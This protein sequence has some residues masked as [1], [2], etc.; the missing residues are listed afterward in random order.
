MKLFKRAVKSLA[1]LVADF[2]GSWWSVIIFTSIIS[3][4][5]IFNTISFTETWHVDKY[6]FSFLNLILGVFAALTGPLVLIG[7]KTQERRYQRLI[8]AIYT[9]EKKQHEVFVKLL[10]EYTGEKE[11]KEEK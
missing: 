10:A 2:M 4:W 11:E 6:P 7:N 9:M 5:V 1:K 3:I 8:E